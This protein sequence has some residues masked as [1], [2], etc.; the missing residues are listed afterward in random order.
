MNSVIN[1]DT[2]IGAGAIVAAMSLVRA[3]DKLPLCRLIADFSAKN[4]REVS[5]DEV[6]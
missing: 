6:E 4:L 1:D 3:G 2:K 5:D